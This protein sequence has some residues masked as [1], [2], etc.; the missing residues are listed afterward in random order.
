MTS[1]WRARKRAGDTVSASVLWPVRERIGRPR[2]GH[3]GP[4]R[5]ML[6]SEGLHDLGELGGPLGAPRVNAVERHPSALVPGQRV[7]GAVLPQPGAAV[8]PCAGVLP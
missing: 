6:R 1:S 3:V 8:A 2:A 7:R 5:V 4:E